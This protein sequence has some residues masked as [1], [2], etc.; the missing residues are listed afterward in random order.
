MN[1][2]LHWIQS[3]GFQ[4]VG[5]LRYHLSTEKP[6]VG[7]SWT[8]GFWSMRHSAISEEEVDFQEH[9]VGNFWVV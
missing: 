3:T 6:F 8:L 1:R 2:Q 4:L 5:P 7:V 9:C